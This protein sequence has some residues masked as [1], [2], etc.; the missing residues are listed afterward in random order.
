MDDQISS[1]VCPVCK[2]IFYHKKNQSPSSFKRQRYCSRSC[3]SKA[4]QNGA[5][6][7]A[8]SHC[9]WKGGRYI[10]KLGYIKIL[11]KSGYR[12][13]H[14]CVAEKK[15]GRK[16][17]TNEVV[18]H[19]NGIV[20]DNRPENLQVIDRGDHARIHNTGKS[21]SQQTK[22]LFKKIRQGTNQ[23]T[24]HPQWKSWV[25]K[26]KI[27]FAVNTHKTKKQA[28]AYLGINPDTLRARMKHYG[29]YGEI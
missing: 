21:A 25:T 5:F 22:E 14:I 8:E 2:S 19:V 10:T 15:I 12:Y 9:N 17:I 26:E 27:V 6:L 7:P 1:K 3:V 18:H 24:E 28:A 20:D 29:I 16:L 11:T 4:T 23:K 13:E